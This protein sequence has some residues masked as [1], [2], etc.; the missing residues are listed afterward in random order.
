MSV[1]SFLAEMKRRRVWRVAGAYVVVVWMTLEIALTAFDVFGLPHW[2]STLA[3]LGAFLGVPVALTLAWAFDITPEGVVRT[4]AITGTDGQGGVG[5][6]VTGAVTGD[7]PATGAGGTAPVIVRAGPPASRLAGVFGVGI[8]V[9]LIGFGAYAHYGPSRTART[10]PAEV[11]SLAVLPFLDLSAAQDQ[12]YFTDGVT[13]ELLNRLARVP[14]LQVA[15][16]TSSFAFKGTTLGIKEIGQRLNVD[17]VLEG[18]VRREGDRVR[19]A[20]QLTDVASGFELWSETYDR[21]VGGILEIQDEIA[22]AIVD[23]LRLQLSPSGAEAL[24]GT[25]SV[26]AHDDYLLGLA[27]WHRRTAADLEKALSYFQSAVQEDPNYA[28][29]YAGLAQTYAVLPF[30]TDVSPTEAAAKAN[31]AAAHA[32]ALDAHLAEAHAALGQIA[33]ALE[34][35]LGS[36]EAA[37]QKALEFSPSYATGH[38][39]Y[40]ETL[41]ML[42]RLRQAHTEID[43][44]LALDPLSPAAQYTKAYL[45]SVEHDYAAADATYD[46]L[47]RRAPDFVPGWIGRLLTALAAGRWETAREAVPGAYADPTVRTTVQAVVDGLESPARRAP[48]VAALDSLG[49]ALPA[50][51]RG[52]LFAALGANDRALRMV[53]QAYVEGRDPNLPFLLVHPLVDRLRDQPRFRAVTD[54]IGTEAPAA[55]DSL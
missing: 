41:I 1:Q 19:V 7:A 4:P 8:L 9:A 45:L 38:Q 6:T 12:G 16:R 55:L 3:V 25:E 48:A 13:E 27:R 50:G 42:G 52:L 30:Y 31:A 49:N 36:A 26:K 23:E 46:Q 33:Q 22:N 29:A 5:G 39:W 51:Q 54:A 37:Y 24:V 53:E 15:G 47:L 11:Q 44:A 17:A 35:D 28:L 32:L 18:S 20:A 40:A 21:A 14:E 34:W 43:R 2:V 10:T